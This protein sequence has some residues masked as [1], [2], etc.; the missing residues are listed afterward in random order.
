MHVA[1]SLDPADRPEEIAVIGMAV[2]VP[3]ASTNGQFW[4][5]LAAGRE[6]IARFSPEELKRAG[7]QEELLR[8][9]HYVPAAGVLDDIED[10]DAAFFRL[11]DSEARLL[12]PQQ[13][14]LLECAWEAM[15]DAGYDPS[16]LGGVVGVYAGAS[17]S[18]YLLFNLHQRLDKTGADFNLDKLITNDKDYVATGIS[19]R[20]GLTGPSCTV[21]TACSTSLSAVHLACL[22]LLNYECDMALA[23]GATVRVPH[24]V[25]YLHQGGSMLSPDGHCR[26]F[27]ARAGGTVPGSGGGLVVLK[28]LSE[29]LRDGD[30]IRAVIKGSA[31]N[32]DGA[33]RIGF[34]APSVNGQSTVIASALRVSGAQAAAIQYVETHGTA[35]GLG[36][37][38]EIAALSQAFR[39]NTARR[40]FCAI[41]SV[42]GN[43]GHLEAGAG[44][45]GL[46]KTIL[47]LQ[48][49]KIPPS[50]HF[51]SPNAQIEFGESPFYV[52]TR[53]VDW[54]QPT[55]G[56]RRLAGVS[57]FGFGGANCHVIVQEAP[58][59][60]RIRAGVA[61]D[62]PRHMLTL[63]AQSEGAL[64]TLV[65]R[66][67]SAVAAAPAQSSIADFCATS[68]RGRHHFEHRAA[69][70]AA[71]ADE[72]MEALDSFRRGGSH[73]TPDRA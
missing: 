14:V 59:E 39:R 3:G 44:I 52:N 30:N 65:D 43:L 41:G 10:F 66:Y 19:Y 50:L 49:R 28:R 62:R 55:D 72:L 6:T 5:N 42:K 15:E 63:S 58:A 64:H 12:D 1:P 60:A 24:R 68:T 2:R 47:A 71:T 29:A 57:S 8:N 36:D 34:T 27:D 33:D 61:G 31:V 23:G 40:Q 9:P 18:T 7:V 32:A 48:H 56:S 69:F 53:L 22:G 21:Q 25:G 38:I 45:A 11:R 13:R 26:P 4:A 46:V 16:G 70:A 37:P 20:L 17:I 35:T 67:R 51:D 73:P 54:P